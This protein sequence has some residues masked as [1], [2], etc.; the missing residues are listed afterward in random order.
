MRAVGCRGSLSRRVSIVERPPEADDRSGFG[1]WEADSVIG[2]GCDLHTEVERRTRFLM[3]RVIP[4][5]TAERSVGARLAMFAPL[6]AAA[7][8]SVTHDN[9]TGFAR[10][11]RLRD[12]P[13]MATCFAD[14]YS[15]WRRGGNE[16]RN[17]MI[18][19]YLPKRTI[20]EPG[21]ARELQE[22]VDETDNRPMRALGYRTPAEAFADELPDLQ[23]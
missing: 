4:D 5:K 15:S 11:A 20:I 12:E 3:A 22:I 16:N 2:M 8:L 7:R 13:G 1:H 17:G 9:G 14:P 21:M 19:R 23:L 6:P 18:R 10:H